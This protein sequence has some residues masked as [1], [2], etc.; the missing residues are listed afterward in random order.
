LISAGEAALVRDEDLALL[1]T[2]LPQSTS[3][4]RHVEA[5][6]VDSAEGRQAMVEVVDPVNLWLDF[7]TADEYYGR[8]DNEEDTVLATD[9]D[10]TSGV[11]TDW[12]IVSARKG[13]AVDD[14]GQNDQ[15]LD[16]HS[17]QPGDS[18]AAS[19]INWDDSF[20]ELGMELSSINGTKLGKH[21]P[22]ILDYDYQTLTKK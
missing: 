16:D 9:D 12:L 6:V 7:D 18:A 4:D 10:Q 8:F 1:T 20:G 3:I 17:V 19:L 21:G 15:W 13:G 5:G 11:N 2:A 14:L 22:N